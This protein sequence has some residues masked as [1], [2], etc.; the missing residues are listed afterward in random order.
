[1]VTRHC[2]TTV[3]KP[4]KELW[5]EMDSNHRPPDYESGELPTV[6]PRSK[7]A[8]LLS[9]AFDVE[10][11]RLVLFAPK[12]AGRFAHHPCRQGTWRSPQARARVICRLYHQ[13]QHEWPW[14]AAMTESVSQGTIWVTTTMRFKGESSPYSHVAPLPIGTSRSGD[15]PL[16]SNISHTVSA[17]CC[18]MTMLL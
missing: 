15:T 13:Q 8:L 2:A 6:Q 5:R 18:E 10:T 3:A 11:S 12:Y 16:A 4:W 17:R 1:M 14:A 9:Q 7:R